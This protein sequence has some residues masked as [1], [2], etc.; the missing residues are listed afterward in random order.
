MLKVF[1]TSRHQNNPVS[2][3]PARSQ[4]Q[5]QKIASNSLLLV[6]GQH[7]HRCER[8][9]AHISGIGFD[10]DATKQNVADDLALRFSNKRDLHKAALPQVSHQ[11]C[12]SIAVECRLMDAPNGIL[13]RGTLPSDQNSH[14][15]FQTTAAHE[16]P[17]ASL[18][19]CI[20]SMVKFI[21]QN[22]QEQAAFT[23]T[24]RNPF[25]TTGFPAVSLRAQ[26]HEP[27]IA[28]SRIS[29]TPTQPF[30]DIVISRPC[31]RSTT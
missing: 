1:L 5:F 10:R 9:S 31:S 23:G 19:N 30:S 24:L 29:K 17:R 28:A 3:Y 6:T 7:G 11:L 13:F 22:L 15:A 25:E 2:K 12:F 27:A 26:R 14:F 21:H 20:S 16:P 18:L 8:Q 4:S